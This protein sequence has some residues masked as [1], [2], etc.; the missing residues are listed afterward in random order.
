MI[1]YVNDYFM[2]ICDYEMIICNYKNDYFLLF[3]VIISNLCLFY[4]NMLV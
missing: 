1:I 2:I 3:V 4:Y